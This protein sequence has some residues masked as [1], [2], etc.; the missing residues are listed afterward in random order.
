MLDGRTIPVVFLCCFES[1]NYRQFSRTRRELFFYAVRLHECAFLPMFMKQGEAEIKNDFA[2]R[3]AKETA[4][5]FKLLGGRTAQ[6][7]SRLYKNYE[8]WKETFPLKK[9]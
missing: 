7:C 3:P 8:N 4:W 9:Y 6:K 5:R 1:P 2:F